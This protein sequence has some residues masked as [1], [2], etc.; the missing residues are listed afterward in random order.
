MLAVHG[1]VDIRTHNSYLWEPALQEAIAMETQVLNR[2]TRT[3]G[4]VLW[5][6]QY[7]VI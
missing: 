3:T 6:R 1:F 2:H 7:S 4:T 5:P